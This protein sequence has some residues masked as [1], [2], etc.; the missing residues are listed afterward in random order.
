LF[1]RLDV[2]GLGGGEVAEL[3]LGGAE[4]VVGD[5]QFMV[6]VGAVF[7]QDDDAFRERQRL[8]EAR[9]FVQPAEFLVGR[10]ARIERQQAVCGGRGRGGR[11]QAGSLRAAGGRRRL[12]SGSGCGFAASPKGVAAA[13]SRRTASPRIMLER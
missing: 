3:E 8:V 4:V 12:G 11:L 6:A 2:A 10:D 7:R 13:D 1:Q 5:R 9:E